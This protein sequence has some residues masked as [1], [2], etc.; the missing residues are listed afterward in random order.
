MSN[1]RVKKALERAKKKGENR[2]EHGIDV[3]VV[4]ELVA[5]LGPSSQIMQL[6]AELDPEVQET[7]I[8][9]SVSRDSDEDH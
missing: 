8:P 9:G 5:E 1:E 2:N 7:L 6:F 3:T 4:Q